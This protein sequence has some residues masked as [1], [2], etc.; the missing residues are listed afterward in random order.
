MHASKLAGLA[1]AGSAVALSL[2]AT[3]IIGATNV[4]SLSYTAP[5]AARGAAIYR[6]NCSQ[7]HGESL[8]NGEFGPPLKGGNFRAHW[9]GKPVLALYSKV[10]AMPPGNAGSLG[11]VAYLDVTAYLLS[12]NAVPVG[13]SELTANVAAMKTQIIP[14]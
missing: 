10:R 1:V 4:V 11:E 3:P 2:I 13:K 7:C 5:Q 12:A 9:R 14:N 6:A 8:G